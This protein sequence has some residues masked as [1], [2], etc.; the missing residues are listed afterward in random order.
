MLKYV[1]P[2][3]K[4]PAYTCMFCGVLTTMMWGPLYSLVGTTGGSAYRGTGFFQC[5]CDHCKETSLWRD[6]PSKAAK[7]ALILPSSVNAP[8]AHV[9]LPDECKIDFEEARE[10]SAVSPRGAAA[11]LRL[12]VQKLC[13][14]L[15]GSGENINDDIKMLVSRGLAPQVQ[16]ALDI[17]RVTGNHAVHPG[18]IALND[19]P[20]HV[21][22]MFEMINLIVE[23]LIT[24]PKQI[25]DRFSRLPIRDLNSILKRDAPRS[26]QGGAST[27]SEHD[28]SNSPQHPSPHPPK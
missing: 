3:F 21:T 24:R 4:S 11:L 9:D 25:A 14:H 1:Q 19:S 22:V 7:G 26:K 28:D 10:I 13:S 5:R 2:A 6:D 20:E 15:G 12:S 18:E 23:E 17:V 8:A 16:Q 27:I